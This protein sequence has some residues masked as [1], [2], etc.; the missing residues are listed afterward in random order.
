MMIGSC[1]ASFFLLLTIAYTQPTPPSSFPPSW[2]TWVVTSITEVGIDK[3]YYSVGQLV[4]YNM[5]Q[6]LSCRLNQQNLL[7]P[8]PNRPID[9]CD[10]STGK[11]Y[12]LDSTV[13]GSVCSGTSAIETGM[14]I[15]TYPPEYLA[16]ARFFG[17][18]KVN[19]KD[20]NHFVA[21]DIVIDGNHV[22]MDVW[23]AVDNSLPCQISV[24]DLTVT[25]K[26]ITTWAF[27][28][29]SISF[30]TDSINQCLAAKIICEQPDWLCHPKPGIPDSQLIAALTWVCNPI[31][32]DCGP[33]A[34]GGDH[35]IPNTP[36]DHSKWAFN[37]YY[38]L[39][40]Y[41]QGPAACDFNGIAQLVPPPP[42]EYPRTSF[43][44]TRTFLQQL[45][46]DITCERPTIK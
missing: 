12:M 37:A 1:L 2:Y 14:D 21:S 29:F 18:D 38:R 20:C 35:Y 40:R 6:N 31:H 16:V 5:Q 41:T 10:Y 44:N 43:N 13:P 15:I 8:K 25:P 28:G 34:P 19:Q 7:A 36:Q 45:S 27:D 11:H 32:L 17:V 3:P 30:P 46:L 24:T 33:I 9:Q 42:S 4:A 26:K 22:Q 39:N 23:T